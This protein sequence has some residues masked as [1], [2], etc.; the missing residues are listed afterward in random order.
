[1][2][3][4]FKS[5][6]LTPLFGRAWELIVNLPNGGDSVTVT[7]DAWEP[8]ALRMT[9]EVDL[10]GYLSGQAFWFCKVELY[11]LSP[12][13]CAQLI[14]SQGG[15]IKLSAGYMVEGRYGVIFEGTIYQ[16]MFERVA[17]TDAKITLWCYTG[18][19]ETIGN[20]VTLRGDKGMTQ[21]AIIQRI[22][23]GANTPIKI[24]GFDTTALATT[25][26]PRARP[27]FGN[28]HKFI[29][30]VAEANSLVSWYGF[31][32]LGISKLDAAT[33]TPEIE[34]DANS[35]Q[36]IGTP[37]QTQYGVDFTV[38]LDNRLRIAQPPQ[39]VALTNTQ[40][41]QLSYQPPGYRPYLDPS[42][43]YLVNGVQ[44]VGDTKGEEW[45]SSVVTLTAIGGRAAMLTDDSNN[46]ID[47]RS[48]R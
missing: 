37:R 8:E 35:G 24:G 10:K 12:Q 27:V 29:D 32:G 23:A 21:S 39:L 26:L 5:T 45:T 11:N 6:S 48:P 28:P 19:A 20:Y 9:F 1:M 41:A 46:P 30:E 33:D 42:G 34:Y 36:I 16:P 22:C 25:R 13:L 40:I 17:V 2:A 14:D 15:T 7:T 47:P 18:L 43:K 3:E 38:L 31:D 44:H 4:T